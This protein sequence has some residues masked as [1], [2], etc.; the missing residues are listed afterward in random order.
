LVNNHQH[1]KFKLKQFNRSAKEFLETGWGFKDI[2]S[3]DELFKN[4]DFLF[5]Q[6]KIR[7]I[8][9]II[10]IDP[11][12]RVVTPL[13]EALKK[14]YDTMKHSNLFIKTSDKKDLKAHKS[15]ICS[16]SEVFDRM[17]SH[18]TKENQTSEIIADDLHSDVVK[19]LLRFIYCEAYFDKLESAVNLE[20][21]LYNAAEKYEIGELKAICLN[22]IFKRLDVG[23]VLTFA[24]FADLFNLEDL[25]SC[26]ILIIYA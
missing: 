24:H 3:H 20:I 21:E 15:I 9:K 14:L 23:N 10:C 25:F 18:D 8:V 11:I 2:I 1:D 5:P 12:I 22:T 19:D 7:I 16:R 13:T 6:G 26:C 17:F 4:Q